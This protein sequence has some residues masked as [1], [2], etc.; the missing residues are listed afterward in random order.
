MKVKAVRT[1][2]EGSSKGSESIVDNMGLEETINKIGYE[3]ILKILSCPLD[4][5]GV[6][7]TIIY[8]SSPERKNLNEN[9]NA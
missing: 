7:Y 5:Y 4:S 8:K 6:Y 1:H 9:Y 3:N 2:F